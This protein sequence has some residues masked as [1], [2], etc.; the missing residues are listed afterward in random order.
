MFGQRIGGETEFDCRNEIHSAQRTGAGLVTDDL[1]VHRADE[2]SR[3][4]R[5]IHQVG[6]NGRD[7]DASGRV[8]AGSEF[9]VKVQDLDADTNGP[10]AWVD[11]RIDEGDASGENFTLHRLN[12]R[13]DLLSETNDRSIV[14]EE[15]EHQPDR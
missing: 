8:V 4:C 1:R 5:V 13:L 10:L 11:C 2:L 14:G 6:G 9:P 15:I 12:L 3:K 7:G